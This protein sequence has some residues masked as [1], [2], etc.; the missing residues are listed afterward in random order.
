MKQCRAFF[1]VNRFTILVEIDGNFIAMEPMKSRETDELIRVYT[2]IMDRLHAQGV[3]PKR[4]M[5][6][7]EAPR[8]YLD[9]IE[10]R[11]IEWELV[12]PHNHRRNIAEKP[13]NPPRGTSSQTSLVVTSIFQ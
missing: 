1:K 7:N 6:D 10:E 3:K 5:L 9:A 13:S 2:I 11:K 12:P 8:A 4:Q